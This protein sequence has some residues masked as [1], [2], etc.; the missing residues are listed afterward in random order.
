MHRL[1]GLFSA[2]S[3]I[4]KGYCFGESDPVQYHF[5]RRRPVKVF[6]NLPAE[7]LNN[8][9]KKQGREALLGHARGYHGDSAM[10]TSHPCHTFSFE[11]RPPPHLLSKKKKKKTNAGLNI[12]DCST[13]LFF[14]WPPFFYKLGCISKQ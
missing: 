1:F 2:A 3:P 6:F 9:K 11:E 5:L 7:S 10:T 4:T 13:D 8:N 14:P 12:P